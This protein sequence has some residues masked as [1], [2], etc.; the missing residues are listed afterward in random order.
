MWYM[1]ESMKTELLEIIRILADNP[2]AALDAIDDV[3]K[4]YERRRY[5]RRL[6][7]AEIYKNIKEEE[8]DNTYHI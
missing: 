6:E 7:W 4:R 1:I 2:E 3:Y 5:R 8:F